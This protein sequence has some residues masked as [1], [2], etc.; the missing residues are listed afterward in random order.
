M[1]EVPPGRW[2]VQS[3]WT[4]GSHEGWRHPSVPGIWGRWDRTLHPWHQGGPGLGCFGCPNGTRRG[5]RRD[6]PPL[7]SK[8]SFAWKEEG[9]HCHLHTPP[10]WPTGRVLKYVA[11]ESHLQKIFYEKWSVT[12]LQVYVQSKNYWSFPPC[13]SSGTEQVHNAS[14][15]L[16]NWFA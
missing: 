8:T 12:Y 1:A 5:S 6:S 16:N 10:P 4:G 13:T 9:L 14:C 2:L 7:R 15:P 11:A 3:C